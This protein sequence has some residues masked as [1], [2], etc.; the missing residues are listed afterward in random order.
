GC[1]SH[2]K[3]IRSFSFKV[4][5]LL[6]AYHIFNMQWHCDLSRP[7]RDGCLGFAGATSRALPLASVIKP[8]EGC[9]TY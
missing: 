4:Q 7:H 3:L 5:I 9:L 8:L 6:L 1:F 2:P